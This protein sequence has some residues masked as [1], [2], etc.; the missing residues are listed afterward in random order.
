M[1][2]EERKRGKEA[3][4]GPETGKV[5]DLGDEVGVTGALW[6][7]FFLFLDLLLALLDRGVAARCCHGFMVVY[8]LSSG[9][10]RVRGEQVNE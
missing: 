5:R 6:P 2:D 9:E 10:C 7:F 4:K 3:R 1:R 8:A